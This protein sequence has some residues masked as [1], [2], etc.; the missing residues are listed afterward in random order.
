[1]AE[2][3]M[4]PATAQL[5]NRQRRFAT[6][7]LTLPQGSE[8]KKVVGAES[9]L[10]VRLRSAV[11]Y[12]GR[13][14][15]IIMP[16]KTSKLEAEVIVEGREEARRAAEQERDGVKILPRLLRSARQAT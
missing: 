13:V 12:A 7:L 5:E 1:M 16:A 10:G 15:R 6:R 11:G 14:E 8:A 3:S 2:A 9:E 4:R